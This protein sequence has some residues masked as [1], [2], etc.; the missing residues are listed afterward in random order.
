MFSDGVDT[1][2]RMTEGEVLGDGGWQASLELREH[3]AAGVSVCC[4]VGPPRSLTLALL[5]TQQVHLSA[6]VS[7]T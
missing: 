2:V 4:L 6:P 1:G 3:Q 5:P 7:A